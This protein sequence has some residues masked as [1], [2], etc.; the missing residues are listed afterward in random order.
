MYI[1]IIYTYKKATRRIGDIINKEGITYAKRANISDSIEITCTS[2][3]LIILKDHKENF[4]N[5]PTTRLIKPTKNEIVRIT[6]SILDKINICLC[7]NLQ[8]NRWRNTTV[9]I[10]WFE[11]IDEKHLHTFT[12]FNIKDLYPSIK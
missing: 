7:E 11:K 5:H 2:N 10:N 4:A 9:V 12:I 3:C 1:Y 6:K 8:L